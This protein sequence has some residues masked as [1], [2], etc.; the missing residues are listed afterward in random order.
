MK[1]FPN[2]LKNPVIIKRR[3]SVPNS[4]SNHNNGSHSDS[5]SSSSSSQQIPSTPSSV[6]PTPTTQRY[7]ATPNVFQDLPVELYQSIKPLLIILKAQ[8]QKVY[9]N[10]S[11]EESSD[12]E[13]KWEVHYTNGTVE[14]LSSLSLIGTNMQV[15]TERTGMHY[16]LPLINRDSSLSNF[17]VFEDNLAFAE[18]AI[19]LSSNKSSQ[20]NFVTNLCSLSIFENISA[21]K[22]LTGTVISTM[23][24]H[25]PD[26]HIILSSQYNFKDWC[27]IYIEGKGWTKAWCHINKRSNIKD[28][29]YE[30]KGKYQ[31]KIYKDI[32]S[33]NPTSQSNL[34]CYIPDCDFI[35]DVFFYNQ[36]ATFDDSQQFM[37]NLNAIKILGDIRFNNLDTIQEEKKSMFSPKRN[38]STSSVKSGSA[39]NFEIKHNGLIIRPI[40]HKGLPHLDSMIKFIVP[41]F[42]VT[43]K[44]G[45]PNH[46]NVS[47]DDKNSLMFGL[48]KLPHTNYFEINDIASLLCEKDTLHAGN[49]I[50]DPLTYSMSWVSEYLNALKHAMIDND[51]VKEKMKE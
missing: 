12:T 15:V 5:A 25:L 28:K 30:P 33:N 17:Q 37:Q 34:I 8:S 3:E 18:P 29:K 4:F 48:P 20:L 14:K 47:R 16:N 44:Y 35:Q 36:M 32:K 13:L 50:D 45:R 42:D 40:A 9:Y 24:L 27:E 23:G 22:A 46:F 2:G 51:T 6:P 10:W 49:G 43:R 39:T 21:Y 38:V 26:I 19:A 31:I 7:S 11:I 41:I 1:F